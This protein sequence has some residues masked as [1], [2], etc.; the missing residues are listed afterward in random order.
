MSKI[1][2]IPAPD[3]ARPGGA[4]LSLRRRP[5]DPDQNPAALTPWPVLVVDDDPDVHAMTRV[6]LRDFSFQGRPFEV[7]SAM[8]AAEARGILAGRTDIPVMLLDVV[9]ETP[10]AGLGLV[11]HVREDLD[12]RRLSI[13]LRTGQPGEAPERDVM[14]AYDINDYRSKTEL[15]AQKLFTALVGGLRS[16]THLSTIED[17]ASTLERRVMER[18]NQLDEARRFAER[19][20]EVLPHPL[21]F[22]DRHGALRLHNRAFREV[23]GSGRDLPEPLARLD[24]QS[25]ETLYAGDQS[26]LSFETSMDIAGCPR[27]FMVSKGLVAADGPSLEESLAGTIGIITDI[28]DLKRMEAQLRHLATTDELT[29]CLNRRAFFSSAE[30]EVERANRYTNFLSVLMIDIDHFKLVNDQYG[31]AVGDQALRAASAAIRAN[32][33]EIDTMGRLGGEE[34]A[35]LLPE[36]PLAGAILVA[37]R[38]RQ[39]VAALAIETGTGPMPLTLTTSLGVAERGNDEISLDQILARADAALYRAKAAG[40]NQVFA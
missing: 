35:I 11:R 15:T 8:S 16:W 39:A 17:M 10:D 22:K 32:L 1:S 27:S 31:H 19:L 23:F 3:P 30:Q 37:E 26:N 24:N 21:W 36:T 25:D 9:M 14:L 2:E 29:G 4:K 34:F 28:T 40:R 7:I 20:V 5:V 6:L 13:V 12:N 33:R 18:T 38:L